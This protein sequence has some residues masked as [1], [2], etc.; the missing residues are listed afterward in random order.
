MLQEVVCIVAASIQLKGQRFLMFLFLRARSIP[1]AVLPPSLGETAF[2]FPWP[3]AGI[4]RIPRAMIPQLS[5]WW[6]H[7]LKQQQ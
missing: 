1:F 7:S 5:A 3:V 2:R 4:P 6:H